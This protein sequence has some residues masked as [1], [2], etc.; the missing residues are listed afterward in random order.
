MDVE[1]L[2]NLIVPAQTKI[3]MIIMDGLGGLPL[4][5]GGKTELETA[6]TPHLDALAEYSALGLPYRWV[7]E[8]HRAAARSPVIFGCDPIQNEIGRGIEALGVDFD[9]ARGCGSR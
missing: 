8:L 6:Y 7:R 2:K 5:P 1:F 3:A 9:R 4:E